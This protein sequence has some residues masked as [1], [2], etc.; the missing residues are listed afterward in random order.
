M[1]HVRPSAAIALAVLLT[2]AGTACGRSPSPPGPTT[3]TGPPPAETTTPDSTPIRIPDGQIAFGCHL[4]EARSSGDICVSRVDGGGLKR[5]TDGPANEFDPSWSSD[6]SRIAFRSAPHPGAAA[7]GPSDIWVVNADGTGARHLTHHPQADNWSPAWSP[8]GRHIAYYSEEGSRPGLYLMGSDGGGSTRILD[9]DAE[10]PCW[11]PDGTRLAFMSL[12]FPPGGSS[13]SYDIY[14]VD[15]DGTGLRQLTDLPGEDG[16]PAWWPDGRTIAFDHEVTE[17]QF[18]FAAYLV[19]SDGTSPHPITPV[20]GH[21]SYD[22][23]DWSSDGSLI[24]FSGYP[25]D[26]G[27]GGGMFLMRSDGSAITRIQPDGVSPVWKP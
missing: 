20:D 18:V 17:S 26:G 13:S 22:Y 23:P 3:S 25:P 6:G 5:L 24:L 8:D 1:D 27:P 10:Y 7:I 2:A 14:V 4:D 15:A 11:S 12:G 9:G 19:G 16:W 21:L